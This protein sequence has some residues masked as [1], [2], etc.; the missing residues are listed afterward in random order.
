MLDVTPAIQIPESELRFSFARSSGP[1]GQNVNK[2]SSKAILHWPVATSPSIPDDVRERF[3]ASYGSRVTNEGEVVITSER[4]RDQPR[5]VQDCLD[6][7]REMLLAVAKPPRRRRKTKP[8]KGSI[9]RRLQSK[10]EKS[11]KKERRRSPRTND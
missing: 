8:T 9:E 7:L 4:Y 3:L 11:E 10:R 5:N 6:K 2:V 1:G